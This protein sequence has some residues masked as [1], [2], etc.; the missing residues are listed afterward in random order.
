MSSTSVSSVY[1]L[2]DCNNFFVS[3]EKVFNPKLERKPVVVLS[4]NDG[5][6]VARSQE[7][8]ALGIPMGAPAFEFKELF[9]KY[10]VEVFSSNFALYLDMSWRVMHILRDFSDTVDV[11]SVDEAFLSFTGIQ[12]DL[13]S[14]AAKIRERILQWVGIP[15]SIGIAPTKTLAKVAG[16]YAKGQGGIFLLDGKNSQAA[17]E[18]LPVGEIWGIGRRLSTRLQKKGIYTAWQLACLPDS[19]LQKELTVVGLRLAWELRGRACLELSEIHDP[20][21]S[22]STAK[23]FESPIFDLEE[24]L[25]ILADYTASVAEKLRMQSSLASYL[26]VSLYTSKHGDGPKYFE[27]ASFVLPEPT[28]Y[29]PKLIDCAK[30]A[31]CG[32]YKKGYA[33]KRVGVMLGGFA[34][35]ADHALD[36]FAR[37]PDQERKKEAKLMQ[38]VD[39]ANE[40]WGKKSL[41]FAAESPRK[42]RKN[43]AT[44]RYTTNWDDLLTVYA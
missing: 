29:T 37:R 23:S 15:V 36:M 14:Y 44:P 6:V 27:D 13:A 39:M 34:Q 18:K 2:V 12:E 31:L 43:F 5:C 33:Y 9:R 42:V 38:V 35:E 20:K 22:I 28:S 19:W 30:K 3:C 4:S 1:A 40:K 10:N 17:L 16:H 26:V 21:K 25:A 8:K 24:L 7:A 32:I 11:Y 41:H